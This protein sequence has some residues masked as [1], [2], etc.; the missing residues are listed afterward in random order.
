MLTQEFGYISAGLLHPA[1]PWICVQLPASGA[2][3]HIQHKSAQK[4]WA[5]PPWSTGAA[6]HPLRQSYTLI[7]ATEDVV[8]RNRKCLLPWE[9]VSNKAASFFPTSV[10]SCQLDVFYSDFS[11]WHP[12]QKKAFSR[13]SQ[14][15]Y[16]VFTVSFLPLR[17][18]T[19][20]LHTRWVCFSGLR[21]K[22]SLTSIFAQIIPLRW[23]TRLTAASC[24][25][26]YSN[27]RKW[28]LKYSHLLY[29]LHP[30]A[31]TNSVIYS[32]SR[33]YQVMTQ[34]AVDNLR[35]CI[36]KGFPSPPQCHT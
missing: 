23:D 24:E 8:M 27:V 32:F 30:F 9:E 29:F 22:T 21:E 33:N 28:T 31:L 19:L 4:W 13:T 35:T 12:R 26:T 20:L 14:R 10:R 36:S 5:W 1:V 18:S 17:E 7:E 25:Q 11:H 6:G 2:T 16:S 15:I 34:K 3:S